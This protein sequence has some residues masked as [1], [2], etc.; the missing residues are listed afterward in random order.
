M[1]TSWIS[2][3]RFA[4]P[5]VALLSAA[6]CAAPHATDWDLVSARDQHRYMPSLV[7]DNRPAAIVTSG[8]GGFVV[9]M[10]PGV[11]APAVQVVSQDG[12]LRLV[13]QETLAR[14][15]ASGAMGASPATAPQAP[16]QP[17]PV[18]PA[19]PAR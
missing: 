11:P 9:G 10:G 4:L 2:A 14:M 8:P 6:G 1:N 19:A 5:A 17:A 13:S 7:M 12:Q 16:G 18:S 15:Q 3:A